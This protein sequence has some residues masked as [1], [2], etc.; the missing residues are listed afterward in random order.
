[1]PDPCEEAIGP[2]AIAEEEYDA[3]GDVSG[4]INDDLWRKSHELSK[5]CFFINLK[6]CSDATGSALNER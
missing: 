1:M 5:I 6:L 4:E 2:E 3:G